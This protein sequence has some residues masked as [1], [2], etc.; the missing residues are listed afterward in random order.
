MN[1]RQMAEA[2]KRSCSTLANQSTQDAIGAPLK[3]EVDLKSWVSLGKS[4]K[5]ARTD[6]RQKKTWKRARI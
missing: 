2:V 1:A 5:P 3:P 4:V 6:R